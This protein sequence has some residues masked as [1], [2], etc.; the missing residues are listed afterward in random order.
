MGTILLEVFVLV[1]DRMGHWWC[2]ACVGT[3]GWV[4]VVLGIR[5]DGSNVVLGTDWVCDGRLLGNDE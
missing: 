1:L 3:D 4:R 2:L 5:W